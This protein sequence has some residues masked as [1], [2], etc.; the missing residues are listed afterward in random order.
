[1]N[2]ELIPTMMSL[3]REGLYS[4]AEVMEWADKQILDGFSD[5]E[6]YMIELALNGPSV[7]S[8]KP[9]YEFFSRILKN[10]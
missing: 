5:P 3:W 6:N 8:N 2:D 7:C 9:L 10:I 4:D 1:M